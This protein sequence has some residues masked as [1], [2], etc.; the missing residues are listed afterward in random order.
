MTARGPQPHLHGP[1]SRQQQQQQQQQQGM[2][3]KLQMLKQG[4]APRGSG[5]AL[6]LTAPVAPAALQQQQQKPPKVG[7]QAA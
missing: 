1:A 3:E 2:L 5:A 4:L 7:V 6:G